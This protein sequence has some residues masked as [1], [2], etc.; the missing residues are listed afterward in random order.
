MRV[1]RGRRRGRRRRRRRHRRRRRRRCLR[2]VCRCQ[3]SE[4]K[5]FR[6]PTSKAISLHQGRGRMY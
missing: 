4:N 1:W 5:I 6:L 3:Q 2:W